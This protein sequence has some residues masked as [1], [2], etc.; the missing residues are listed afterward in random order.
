MEVGVTELRAD[1][2]RW[3]ER[4]R[5]GDEIVVTDRGIPVVRLVAVESAA[6]LEALTS[7]GA[8]ARPTSDSRPRASGRD[9]PKVRHSLADRIAAER[10]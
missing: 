2:S 1:L 7:Q 5:R 4:V 8:I 3:L 9:R 6:R 10:R